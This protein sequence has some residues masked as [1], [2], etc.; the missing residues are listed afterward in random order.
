MKYKKTFENRKK[1]P[2]IGDYALVNIDIPIFSNFIN[3]N[4][5]R[6]ISINHKDL[7]VKVKYENV[8]KYAMA[9]MMPEYDEYIPGVNQPWSRTFDL[10]YLIYFSKSKENVELQKNVNK[11]N[12]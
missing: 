8:P 1:I 6:I 3:N 9:F 2:K 5:G 7:E 11:Y 4:I 10:K 12:L